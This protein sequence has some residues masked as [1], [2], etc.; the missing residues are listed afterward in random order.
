[1]I[2]SKLNFTS[3]AVSRMQE[4]NITT[5]K[6]NEIMRLGQTFAST[7]GKYIVKYFEIV[8]TISKNYR[9]IFSKQDNLVITVYYFEKKYDEN[10][11]IRKNKTCS[12]K[13]IIKHKKRSIKQKD[14]DDY[15]EEEMKKF[16]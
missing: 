1:M 7:S 10:K 4:R 2:M 16:R 14:A 6:I 12:E 15:F 9:L 13:K 8:G 11:S 3:H 5:S